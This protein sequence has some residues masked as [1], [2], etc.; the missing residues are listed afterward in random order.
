MAF[1]VLLLFFTAHTK[2]IS[3][4]PNVELQVILVCVSCCTDLVIDCDVV[5]TS[6]NIMCTSM[7]ASIVDEIFRAVS[8]SIHQLEQSQESK[9]RRAIPGKQSMELLQESNPRRTIPG[10]QSQESNPRRA[11]P[12]E[13]S[14]ESNQGSNPRRAIPGKQSH[15]S[16]PGRAIPEELSRRAVEE[17]SKRVI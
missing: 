2:R 3:L 7:R 16:N 4:L 11:S 14:Q 15:E 6:K 13:Q 1:C 12:G 5:R 9:P 17:Q 10:E 8:E